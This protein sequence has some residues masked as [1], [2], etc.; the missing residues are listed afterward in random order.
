MEPLA[1]VMEYTAEERLRDL[2]GLPASRLKNA[3][4]KVSMRRMTRQF[5]SRVRTL[6]PWLP[7]TDVPEAL[8]AA[9]PLVG[10]HPQG[11]VLLTERR[12]DA[13]AFRLRRSPPRAPA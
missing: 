12:L 11:K 3:L 8:R 2:F 9:Q 5:Y 4:V 13:F 10:R 7:I 1:A 6:H